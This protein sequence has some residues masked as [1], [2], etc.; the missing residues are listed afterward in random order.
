[1]VLIWLLIG[2]GLLAIELVVPTA[3]VSTV[4]GVAAL[5]VAALSLVF[6]WVAGQIMVWM[7]LSSGLAW[8]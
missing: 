7:L 8:G 2:L 6:P 1:M 5:G 3:F 4:M